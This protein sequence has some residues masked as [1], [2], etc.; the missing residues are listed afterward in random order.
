MRAAALGQPG[1]GKT[2]PHLM[3]HI[4]D[5]SSL[6]CRGGGHRDRELSM[7]AV[8]DVHKA[9]LFF[10]LLTVCMH[11]ACRHSVYAACTW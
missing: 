10:L 11:D 9:G 4:A 8:H 1:P 3:H 6:F 5:L 7:V 2:H